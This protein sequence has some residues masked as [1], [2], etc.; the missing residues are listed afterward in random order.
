MLQQS[1]QDTGQNSPVFPHQAAAPKECHQ[2]DPSTA[3]LLPLQYFLHHK[4]RMATHPQPMASQQTHKVRRFKMESLAAVLPEFTKGWWGTTLDLKNMSKVWIQE[5]AIRTLSSPQ[6]LHQHS[7][8]GDGAPLKKRCLRLC[9]PGRLAI[10]S[11][12]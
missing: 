9:I 6:I 5:P 10:Y 11:P 1:H 8:D 7:E 2:E 12:V 3:S 4:E